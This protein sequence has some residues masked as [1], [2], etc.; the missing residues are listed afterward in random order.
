MY[1]MQFFGLKEKLLFSALEA[2]KKELYTCPECG[3]S[4]RLR[5]GPHRSAHFYHTSVPKACQQHLKSLEHLNTQMFLLD[6]LPQGEAKMEHPFRE[7]Q[8]IADVVWL[9][10]NIVFEV[11]CS[12]ISLE[13]VES[14]NRDYESLGFTVVWILHDKRFNKKNLSAAENYLR[15]R[16]AY[17][18]S[19]TKAGKGEIY[20][21]AEHIDGFKREK[22]IRKLPISPSQPLKFSLP[23]EKNLPKILESRITSSGLFFEG[24]L[25]FWWLKDPESDLFLNKKPKETHQSRSF[26]YRLYRRL[27]LGVLRPLTHEEFSRLRSK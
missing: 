23:G 27:L 17:F 24:D 25:A 12:P 4:L 9:E 6:L 8:R 15:A 10:R 11:Q 21:Q 19:I 13:E 20:D 14:R 7:V 22:R 1:S 5:S 2:Q 3:G 26:L 18:S 16:G